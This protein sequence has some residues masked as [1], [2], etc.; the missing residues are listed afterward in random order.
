MA[1]AT[2]TPPRTDSRATAPS[3]LLA[4]A[5]GGSV[6]ALGT[7]F[8]SIRGHLTL[9]AR[10]GFPRRFQAILGVSDVVQDAVVAGHERFHAFRGG[11][12]AE[13]L[14]W[15][16][17]ILSHTMVDSIRRQSALRR[18]GNGMLFDLEQI[19]AQAA[20]LTDG[21]E[22]RPLPTVIRV[23]EENLVKAALDE[24]PADQRRVLWLHH[25]EGR[26]FAAIGAELGRSEEAARKLWVRGFR[27][28]EERLRSLADDPEPGAGTSPRDCPRD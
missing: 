16:R 9:A 2:R 3:K 20:A 6:E 10:R 11:S 21:S 17:V 28:I 15:M 24:L 27:K 19:G 4:E 7:L 23:E 1:T 14:G 25:W 22:R 8:Q 5:R 12:Q 18:L 13:F 26:T